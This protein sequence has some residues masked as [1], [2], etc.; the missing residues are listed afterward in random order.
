MGTFLLSGT[1]SL[2]V[3]TENVGGSGSGNFVQSGGQNNVNNLNVAAQYSLTAGSL[4]ATSL[5]G[6][7][8]FTQTGR[9]RNRHRCNA[10]SRINL[11]SV[12]SGTFDLNTHD[13]IISAGSITTIAGDV[14][15]SLGNQR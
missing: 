11:F 12:S 8:S 14:K 10:V 4:V 13:L 5:S 2:S 1:G 9:R 3:D 15:S 7:G 6:N